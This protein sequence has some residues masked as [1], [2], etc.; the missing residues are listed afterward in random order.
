MLS[1]FIGT[2]LVAA[3]NAQLTTTIW[4][5]LFPLRS[6]K[7]GYFGSVINAN[8]SHTTY[9]LNYDNGTDYTALGFGLTTQMVTVGPSLYEQSSTRNFGIPNSASA[10]DVNAYILRCEKEDPAN[11]NAN[12]T[13]T[14]SYGANYVYAMKCDVPQ[15]EGQT[16]VWTQT[17]TYDDRLS[18]S[19]GVETILETRTFLPDTEP[20]PA[21][22]S[23]G[24][25]L[26]TEGSAMTFDALPTSFGTF[27]VVVTAGMEKLNAT[28]GAGVTGSSAQ[29][30]ATNSL[31]T[32]SPVS[33]SSGLPEA[34][35][36]AACL[37]RPGGVVVALGVAVAALV[38]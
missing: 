23:D 10:A 11:Q 15:T 3:A 1:L 19:A 38:V 30:T 16:R 31:T 37:L 2:M 4:A 32:A 14:V 17:I 24:P 36:A 21:W 26:R 20:A 13:C 29:P 6:D 12:A 22:C 18:Y 8:A 34:T 5:P 33:G 27:Q 25:G 28:Q 9:L 35:G 7:I